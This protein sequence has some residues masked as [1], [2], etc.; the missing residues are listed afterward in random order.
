[1]EDE[2]RRRGEVRE[3]VEFAVRFF[4]GAGDEPTEERP[5]V[6]SHVRTATSDTSIKKVLDPGH[7]DRVSR[8]AEESMRMRAEDGAILEQVLQ[9]ARAD[10]SAKKEEPNG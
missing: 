5:I 6:T 1:M 8:L 9:Q 10:L 4:S 2:R 3:V 7:G